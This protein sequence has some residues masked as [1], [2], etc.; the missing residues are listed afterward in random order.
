MRTVLQLSLFITTRLGRSKALILVIIVVCC[1]RL[2]YFLARSFRVNNLKFLLL[3]RSK[4]SLI[5]IDNRGVDLYSAA[6]NI[7]KVHNT[8]RG[9]SNHEVLRRARFSDALACL[10][11][12]RYSICC[13]SSLTLSQSHSVF[14]DGI[15][16]LLQTDD[17]LRLVRSLSVGTHQV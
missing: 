7:E 17:C 3:F 1:R 13:L 5:I 14:L 8:C 16:Q 4:R 2:S 10:G 12:V 6:H 9:P 15:S 11:S